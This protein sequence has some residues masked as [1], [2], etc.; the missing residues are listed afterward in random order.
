M[1]DAWLHLRTVDGANSTE[2]TI[3][4]ANAKITETENG[5]VVEGE[6]PV[7][8]AP[9]FSGALQLSIFLTCGI[10]SHGF[11]PYETMRGPATAGGQFWCQ[12]CQDEFDSIDP[13][14]R[15]DR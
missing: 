7:Q 14:E 13:D 10:C 12:K 2:T 1:T 15:S 4:V 9:D 5:Y 6:I 8:F 3:H 11:E